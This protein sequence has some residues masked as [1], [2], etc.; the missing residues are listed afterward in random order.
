MDDLLGLNSMMISSLSK[1]QVPEISYAPFLRDRDKIYLYLSETA[2][3]YEN[4]STH[5][6]CSVMAIEDEGHLDNIYKRRRLSFHAHAEKVETVDE[7]IETLYAERHGKEN[8]DHIKTAHNFDWFVL[9]LKKGRLVE[10]FGKAYDVFP[11]VEGEFDLRP[12]TFK[13]VHK[14]DHT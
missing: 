4:L 6:D 3:H 9:T 10:G 11:T 5:R 13:N 7:K 12:V 1:K 8:Y 14:H 2:N